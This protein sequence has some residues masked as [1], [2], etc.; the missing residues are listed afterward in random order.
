MEFEFEQW[1][2]IFLDEVK[3]LGY[4]GPVD[5]GTF[6]MDWEIGK[7][8]EETAKEFVAEMED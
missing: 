4:K 1:F 3:K 6:E 2:D 8:P 7:S 5:M